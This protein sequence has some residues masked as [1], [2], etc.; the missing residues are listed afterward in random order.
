MEFDS[1]SRILRIVLIRY[2]QREARWAEALRAS[3]RGREMFPGDFNLDLLHVRAL[4]NLGG[5]LDAIEVLAETHVLPSENARE[6]HHLYALAH[7]GAALDALD[8]GDHQ[9]ARGYLEAALL[10]P[11]SLGQGR[12]NDPDERLVR[13]LLGVAAERAGD[14]DGARGA[15]EA[16]AEGAAGLADRPL[17]R[18][19]LPV[20]MA[21]HALGRD[22]GLTVAAATA[23]LLADNPGVLADLEGRLLRRAASLAQGRTGANR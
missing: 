13:Y 16:A 20:I 17:D 7:V 1:E 19:D 2:L 3:A 15:F 18:G 4:L 12:P 23:R 6:S 8:A 5:F 11:E 22:P 14:G 10:W 21:L 9:A